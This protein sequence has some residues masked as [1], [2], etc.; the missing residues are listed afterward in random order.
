MTSKLLAFH[1]D[2]GV[3]VEADAEVLGIQCDGAQQPRQP[4]ALDEV[5]VDQRLRDQPEARAG[6]DR[7]R[8]HAG[9]GTAEDHGAAHRRR[10]RASA[11]HDQAAV[12]QA[13]ADDVVGARADQ[14][15]QLGLVAAAEEHASGI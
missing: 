15:A 10:A 11:S 3:L 5:H 7:G 2:A 13:V 4:P 12:G 1:Q 6:P 9:P 14:R 8:R